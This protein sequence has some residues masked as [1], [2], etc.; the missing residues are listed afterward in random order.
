MQQ[1]PYGQHQ[2]AGISVTK[3]TRIYRGFTQIICKDE[4]T[5]SANMSA[6]ASMTNSCDSSSLTTA[7]VRPAALEALPLV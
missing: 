7:A 4:L 1:T 3:H 5:L 6:P 2:S